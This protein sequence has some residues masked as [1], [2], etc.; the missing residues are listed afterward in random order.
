M[1]ARRFECVTFIFIVIMEIWRDVVSRAL[2]RISYVPLFSMAIGTPQTKGRN[3][4]HDAF[5]E[6]KVLRNL[7][8]YSS[9]RVQGTSRSTCCHVL[10]DDDKS[11][12][13]G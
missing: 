3:I 7:S 10:L 13:G 5:F 4:L 9:V 12:V 1:N 2:H 8:R 11:N 6:I